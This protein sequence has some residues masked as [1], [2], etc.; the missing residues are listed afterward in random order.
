MNTGNYASINDLKMYYELHGSG[1]LPL[2]L[3]HG[4]GST[5]DSNFGNILPGLA[6]SRK[7]I[8]VELQAHGRTSDRDAPESFAQDADDVVELLRHLNIQKADFLGFSNGGQTTI[9]I[10][11]RH[12]E[13]AR[14]LIIVSAFYKRSGTPPEFWNMFDD[15]KFEMMPAPLK[16][17]FLK[18]NNDPEA[19]LNMFKKDAERM[20]NFEG[21]TDDEMR[22]IQTPSLIVI[23]DRDV[24]TTEHAVE[25]SRMIPNSRL[26]ILPGDHGS[27]M[28]DIMSPGSTR[29]PVLFVGLI[30]EF[31]DED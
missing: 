31:L 14:K 17:A 30:E 7:I 3:I 4:G 22:S 5:I 16:D 26:A 21:W 9:E 13:Y 28:N 25:M 24:P 15:I 29:I 8:A 1:D 6:K 23:G 18:V 20:K 27:F 19:L 12:A 10:G 11:L 2:V